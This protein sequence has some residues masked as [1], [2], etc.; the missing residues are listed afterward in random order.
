MQR[1]TVELFRADLLNI[2]TE[3]QGVKILRQL[4]YV[5]EFGLSPAVP[6]VRKV[7][8]TPFVGIKNLGKG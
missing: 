7:T 3:K 1:C 2:C 6:S 4:K 8:G 5:Q